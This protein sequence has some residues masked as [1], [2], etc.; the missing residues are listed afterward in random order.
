VTQLVHGFGGGGGFV[1]EFINGKFTIFAKA[2]LAFV[3]E[4]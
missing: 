4:V 3:G 1:G 2:A